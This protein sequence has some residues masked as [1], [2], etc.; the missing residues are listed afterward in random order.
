[1]TQGALHQ[2]RSMLWACLSHVSKYSLWPQRLPPARNGIRR[3]DGAKE[4]S[5]FG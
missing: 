4:A 3:R 2:H 5:V 1:M